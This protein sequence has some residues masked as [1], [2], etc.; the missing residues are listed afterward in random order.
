MNFSKLHRCA[1]H[2][3][4]DAKRVMEHI[5]KV[6][7]V[8][9][10]PYLH[11]SAP[12]CVETDCCAQFIVSRDAIRKYPKSVYE[13]WYKFLM[14]DYKTYNISSWDSAVILEHLWYLIYPN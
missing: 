8:Y 9:F 12:T 14:E 10:K 7:D 5:G 11:M 1:N 3:D 4:G 13:H 2:T 6:W